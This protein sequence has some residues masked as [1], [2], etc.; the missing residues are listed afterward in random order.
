MEPGQLHQLLQPKL[1]EIRKYLIRLGANPADAEDIVQ[2]TVYKAFL[3]IESIEANKF[4]AWL[5]K[6]AIN[7]YYDLCR[8]NKRIQVPI[9]SVQI[10]DV[11]LPEDKLLQQE[12]REQIESILAN[13]LPHHKQLLIMKYELE[14]S[15]LEISDLL[16]IK[17]ENVKSGLFQA[18]KQFQKRY[19]G[20]VE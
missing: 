12:K 19:R 5:Y 15:Y 18:R 3:Y 20:D 14:L 16:G 13:L 11:D 10:A 7:R 4:S 17:V 2:D 1:T 9:E 8:R 6:V